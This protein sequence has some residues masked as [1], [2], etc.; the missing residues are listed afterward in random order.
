MVIAA[1]EPLSS[2]PYAGNGATTSFDFDFTVFAETEL[3]VVLLDTLGVETNQVLNTD[4]TVSP[5]GGSY[6]A[7]GGSVIMTVPPAV[8]EELIILPDITRSQDRPFSAQSSITLQEIEDALDKVTAVCRQL[9]ERSLRSVTVSAFNPGD[10]DAL[11]NNINALIALES[12]IQLIVSNLGSIVTV[13]ANETELQTVAANIAVVAT[14]A[15]NIASVNTVSADIAN[16]NTLA[17]VSADITTLAAAVANLNTVAASIASVNTVAGSIANVNTTATNIADVNTVAAAIDDIIGVNP[18]VYRKNNRIINGNFRIWQR[19][20]SQTGISYGSADRWRVIRDG[21]SSTLSRQ[22]FVLGAILGGNHGRHFARFGVSGQSL[23]SHRCILQQPMEDVRTY[24]GQTVTVLGFL[25]RW[26]GAGGVAFNLT[27]TY[28]GGGSP[29]GNVPAT[30]VIVTPATNGEW[31]PFAATIAVP[32]ITGKTIGTDFTDTLTL[33][34]FISAGDNY[35]EGGGLG[36]QTAEFDF[37]GIHILPGAHPA[38]MA[39]N[40][41][42]RAQEEELRDCQRFYNVGNLAAGGG[43]ATKQAGSA[44]QTNMFNSCH[45]FPTQMRAI[46][47]VTIVGGATLENCSALAA[48]GIGTDGFLTRVTATAS[49]SYRAYN[50]NWNASAEL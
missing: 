24:A 42:E 27:Q 50:T 45:F 7:A 33:S 20:S 35:S 39:L 12:D 19:G 41:R 21:G 43:V 48:A 49:G 3:Q 9:F 46:P 5:T 37:W 34:M 6:P 8:G 10:V 18:A 26:S 47:D 17:A 44:G 25:R 15:A 1:N 40:Y 31:E 38:S 30:P 11:L 36:I 14:V 32:N 13:A 28:G 2:G 29:S 23:A 16:V 22:D 4:Y